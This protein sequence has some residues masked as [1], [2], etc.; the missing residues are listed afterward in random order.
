MRI[1]GFPPNLK[2]MILKF[3]AKVDQK[4]KTSGK[5]PELLSKI[6][7]DSLISNSDHFFHRQI[8]LNNFYFL[9]DKNILNLNE[10]TDCLLADFK[11]DEQ[12]LRL[13]LI[14]YPNPRNAENA[15]ESFNKSY[16]K[17]EASVRNKIIEIPEG[18]FVGLD[19]QNNYLIL[20]FEGKDK[21]IAL[22]L[23][24]SAANSLK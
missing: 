4:I 1:L 11:F 15:Y 13:L 8:L 24:D 21:R 3:G 9:S 5:P 7:K 6:P 2:E 17:N 20:V 23:L 18:K 16:L 14:K 22:Q 19:L 10:K 12:I